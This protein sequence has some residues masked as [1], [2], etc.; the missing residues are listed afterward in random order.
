[1]CTVC[2]GTLNDWRAGL[3]VT[4]NLTE[5]N[6]GTHTDCT[7]CH[8]QPNAPYAWTMHD[9]LSGAPLENRVEINTNKGHILAFGIEAGT[10]KVLDRLKKKQTPAQVEQIAGF[11]QVEV[12]VDRKAIARHKINV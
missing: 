11:A 5:I 8:V 1:M 2:H 6:N 7:Q 12:V 4:H 9:A 3:T 10:Q